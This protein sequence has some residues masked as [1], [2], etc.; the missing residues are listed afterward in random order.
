MRSTILE[1]RFKWK[2]WLWE[3]AGK[4]QYLKY[5]EKPGIP[6]CWFVVL[7]THS[8]YAFPKPK[9]ISIG[10]NSIQSVIVYKIGG[11]EYKTL[12]TALVLYTPF[13]RGFV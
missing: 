5:R 4:G 10:A 8:W 6:K 11:A 3:Q 12:F 9:E 7:A 13:Y 2:S 1:A